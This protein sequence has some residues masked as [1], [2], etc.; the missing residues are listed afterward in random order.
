MG[1]VLAHNEV[2][3]GR[4]GIVLAYHRQYDIGS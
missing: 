3:D 1:I 2:R 4:M